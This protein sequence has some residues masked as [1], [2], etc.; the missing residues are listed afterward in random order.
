M[1]VVFAHLGGGTFAPL[2]LV[3]IEVAAVA[4]FVRARTLRRRGSPVAGWRQACFYGGLALIL[5]ALASPLSHMATELFL[6][7]MAEHL[8]IG[9]IGTLLIVLGLTGPLLQPLLA[10]GIVDRLRVLVNPAVALPLWMANLAIWHLPALYQGTLTSPPLHALQHAMFVGFGITMWM[11]LL[12]PLPKPAWFGNAAKLG[13]ILAV[14]LWGALLGN[15][16]IWSGTVFYP[17]Y[18]AG[19]RSWGISALQDQSTAGVIM[20]LEGSILTILLFGWVFMRAAR[21]TEERQ[22]LLD[23][24]E[25]HGLTLDEARARRAVEAGR[26]ER[27]RERLEGNAARGPG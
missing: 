24:A 26:G 4:Y 23:F 3:P 25:A 7:H 20:M 21:E 10:I 8:V 19:E 17:D 2:E 1:P 9:D 5:F 16:F 27:L 13:Y 6:A 22:E 15:F 14:R 12:G 11:A 18:A